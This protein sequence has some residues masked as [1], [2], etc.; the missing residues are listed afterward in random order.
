MKYTFSGFHPSSVKNFKMGKTHL[1]DVEMQN[2]SD[3]LHNYI[4][5]FYNI[6]KRYIKNVE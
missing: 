3:V 2:G 6:I 1:L 4:V 5:L